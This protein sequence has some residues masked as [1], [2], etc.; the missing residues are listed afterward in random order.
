MTMPA[1]AASPSARAPRI[2][3]VD[4]DEG[5][6]ILMAETLRAEGYAVESLA[7]G[8]AALRW[9]EQHTP[10]LL[11]L[12][13]KLRD[14]DAPELLERLQRAQTRVPF[15]V[16]TGQ[17]DERIAVDIMKRGALDY[18]MKDTA[19]LDLLPAVVKRAFDGLARERALVA[20]RAEHARLEQEVVAAS[21]RERHAI[22]ADLHDGLGQLLTAVE[23]MCAGLKA[24]TAH[25]QPETAARLDQMGAMLRE[26]V[27]QTRYLARGLVPV[28]G[29]PDALHNALAA[30]ADRANGLGR[31]RVEF[32]AADPVEIAD[33]VATSHLY[34]IAQEAVNNALKHARAALI[35]VRLER[36]DGK[37]RLEIADDGTGLAEASEGRGAGLGLMRHRA[38]L[39][40]AELTLKSR[41]GGGVVITCLW[42]LP[43]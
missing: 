17:G 26:A 10:D 40:G 25:T 15:L 1:E 32:K 39:I 6:L 35:T 11:L 28:A 16:V 9:L 12:D 38:S 41:R 31:T 5:L 24:D 18:V 8:T 21:E 33:P 7:S 29:G 19:M 20:A 34:R 30:L 3:V 36:R 22:G 23:F 14:V 27:A 43:S 13:L 37:L 4:D 2:L 42:P